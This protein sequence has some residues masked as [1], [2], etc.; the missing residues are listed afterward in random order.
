MSDQA[1]DL[2]KLVRRAARPQT[3]DAA[4]PK[5]VV[6]TSGKG[7]VGTT[8]IALNLAIALARDGRRTVLVDA[9]LE[10]ADA[11][12]LCQL[13][14]PA[15]SIAEIL[16]GGQSVHETLQRGPGGIQVLP[17]TWSA[18]KLVDC[19]EAAQ[20]RLL[21]QLRCLGPHADFVILDVGSGAN[22]VV[23]RFWDAADHVLLVTTSDVVSVMDAYATV[24]VLCA[25]RA[26]AS[27]ASVVNFAESHSAATEVHQ[28]L[29]QACRRFLGLK[30][31]FAGEIPCDP[32]V[33]AASA[34]CRP[35]VLEY[36]ACEASLHIEHLAQAL[37]SPEG[38]R[39]RP[40]KLLARSKAGARRAT[41]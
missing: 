1:N 13:D 29:A 33:A 23:G 36:P 34:G 26:P 31:T 37:T 8:S 32:R 39:A 16:S 15:G 30:L 40:R 6:V 20:H 18:G 5:L 24:K 25:A 27:L 11:S 7:G 4:S 38:V 41:A 35:F 3:E 17:G 22:R 9:D 10:G 2:R 12:K 14:E 28:R 21:A 19:S